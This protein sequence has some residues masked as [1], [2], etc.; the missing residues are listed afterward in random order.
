MTTTRALTFLGTTLVLVLLAAP[1]LAQSSERQSHE[2]QSPAEQHAVDEDRFIAGG[3]L[4]VRRRIAGNL[5]AAGGSVDIAAPVDGSAAVA[6]GTVRVSAP[7]SQSLYAAA[8]TV[9]LNGP[10][11]HNARIAAGAVEIGRQA[12]VGREA[13]I[14][15][16]DVRII[17][18]IGGDL[19][20]GGGHVFI[21]G[22]IG[23]DV[24]IASGSVELGP[25]A[26]IG[27]RLRYASREELV[28]DPAAEVQGGIERFTPREARRP[29]QRI[30][31]RTR[32]AAG[33]VWS[34]GLALVAA[35]LVAI[36]PGFYSAV[37]ATVRTRWA[38]SLL[39]G[40]I[41]LVCI[42]VAASILMLT[43]IGIP[44][45]IA[46][47]VF[48]VLLLFAGYATAGIGIGEAVLQRLQSARATHTGWRVLAAVLGVLAVSLLGRL[49]WL[50]GFVVFAALLLGIG[51]LLL[52]LAA[53]SRVRAA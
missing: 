23:G 53:R 34:A 12:D 11:E 33:W 5:F 50:G 7:I 8:G 51:A 16:G 36:L 52:Q 37:A 46:A 3:S 49:P 21:D 20:T 4:W 6:G 19:Q 31:A 25:S 35:V 27:G 29:A 10:V 26:R 41:A 22:P 1:L 17:G 45:G 18:R 47:I 40:F 9:T 14:V 30:E 38:W 2:R 43:L 44:L 48:Y 24:E 39:V 28:R 13:S 15:A 32:Q 42:P